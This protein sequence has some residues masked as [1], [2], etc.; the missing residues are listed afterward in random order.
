MSIEVD[1]FVVQPLAGPETSNVLV[2]NL[3]SAGFGH[4]ATFGKNRID[5][6]LVRRWKARW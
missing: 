2:R 1:D 5:I 4:C 3:F 6:C